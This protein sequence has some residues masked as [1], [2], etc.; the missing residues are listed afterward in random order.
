ME[1]GAHERVTT[2]SRIQ[3][4]TLVHSSELKIGSLSFPINA[5]Q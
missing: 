4:L 5:P 2:A 1:G 3:P